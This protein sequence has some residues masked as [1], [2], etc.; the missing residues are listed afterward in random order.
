MTTEQI[1]I[2]Y[3]DTKST[4]IRSDLLQAIELV[5]GPKVAVDCGCG[6]GSNI[7]YLSTNGFTVYG[8]DIEDEAIIRC[9]D[10]FSNNSKVVLSQDSFSTFTY[11]RTSLVLAD[12]SLFFCPENEFD[13]AWHK[14]YESLYVGGVFCGSFL[15]PNDTMANPNYA[16]EG[17]W[18]NSLVFREKEIKSLFKNYLVCSFTE[19]K[20]SGR[21]TQGVPHDWH[22]FSVVA[23]KLNLD[24]PHGI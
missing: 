24:I 17:F 18:P 15:G 23:S 7:G 4:E 2:Y 14:I 21:T 9:K 19:H 22:I 6:A 1:K 16:K 10:R 5:K 13:F 20:F 8:Y 3:D 12:A 11:P